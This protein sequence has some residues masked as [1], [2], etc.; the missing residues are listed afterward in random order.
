MFGGL[1]G[2]ASLA[3]TVCSSR[4]GRR[5]LALLGGATVALVVVPAAQAALVFDG[6]PGSGAPPATLGGYTMVPSPQDTR[7]NFTKVT[8]APATA[9]SS[10]SYDRTMGLLTI[11]PTGGWASS[12]WA[13]GSYGGRVYFTEFA[14]SVKITLPSPASAVYLYGDPNAVG[15]TTME[16]IAQDGT[17]VSS[18]PIAVP[19][20]FFFETTTSGQF[21]GFYGTGGDKIASLTLSISSAQGFS[22][23]DFALGSVPADQPITATGTTLSATEG[24]KFSGTVATFKDP[25]TSATPGEYEANIKW[26]DGGEST[27]TVSGSGGNLT[28]SGEHTYAEEATTYP[29]TVKITDKDNSSN[30]ATATSFANVTDAALTSTC[31]APSTSPQAFAGP[32]ATFTDKD[33]GGSQPADYSAT[34]EWG[35]ST[36]SAGMIP[37]GTGSG[38]YTVNGTHTYTSQG[39]FTITT[40]IK[41]AGGSKTVATCKTLVFAVLP[42]AG[43]FTIGDE[44]AA[45]GHAV[46]FSNTEVEWWGS[47]W[48]KENSLS[49]GPAPSA[50]KGFAESSPNPPKC[51]ETWT[52]NTGNSSGP[53][54]TVPEYMAVIA[55]SKITQS[56]STITGNAPEVVVVKT[57]PGYLPNPGHKGTG[58]VMAI[59]CKS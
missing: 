26:G 44:S 15:T 41:D 30:S 23:G 40:T 54:A 13:G 4:L 53:P 55:A 24:A 19:T 56:G 22:V 28:V 27:G 1:P 9:T 50:F 37:P 5:A 10:F 20:H 8:T 35:D 57:S 36:S 39:T 48:W 47:N 31:A 29:V 49:G 45:I 12:N 6:S 7:A 58:T 16:A 25:D 33:P 46:S 18:G 3:R 21:F 32:T 38:P 11:G 34:I 59:V 2:R 14:S 51:G 43:S 52:T 17:S 42:A